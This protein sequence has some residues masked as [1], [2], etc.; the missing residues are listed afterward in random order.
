MSH[1]KRSAHDGVLPEHESG[2][3][4]LVADANAKPYIALASLAEAREHLDAIVIFEGDYGGQIYVVA[5]I[6]YVKCNEATLLLLLGDLDALEWA[7]PDGAHIFFER[8]RVGAAVA[9]G[10]GG[11]RVQ[12][13]V[14]VH[15]RLKMHHSAISAVLTGEKARITDG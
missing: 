4:R 8:L 11:A 9:G 10:M 3:R 1:K 6:D 2:V 5:P 7:D 15:D 13:G 12:E 14:W